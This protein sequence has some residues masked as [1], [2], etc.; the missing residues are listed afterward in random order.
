MSPRE[1]RTDHAMKQ[2]FELTHP[3]SKSLSRRMFDQIQTIN[4][5]KLGKH[6]RGSLMLRTVRFDG[7]TLTLEWSKACPF[8]VARFSGGATA[9]FQVYRYSDHKTFLRKVGKLKS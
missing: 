1:Q 2:T 5:T 4:A 8:V 3:L 7:K 6:R 9:R